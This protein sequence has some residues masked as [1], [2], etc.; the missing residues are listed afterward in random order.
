MLTEGAGSKQTRTK[1]KK[2]LKL[3]PRC[4]FSLLLTS[5]RMPLNTTIS[6]PAPPEQPIQLESTA[7]LTRG[8]WICWPFLPYLHL[9]PPLTPKT[10]GSH[11]HGFVHPGPRSQDL[12]RCMRAVSSQEDLPDL[13]DF[14]LSGPSRIWEEDGSLA[15]CLTQALAFTQTT[16]RWPLPFSRAGEKKKLIWREIV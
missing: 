13:R 1:K 6:F 12:G 10:R 4:S 16:K 2:T 14:C 11:M 8:C 7:D 9:I 15:C 5:L 3:K